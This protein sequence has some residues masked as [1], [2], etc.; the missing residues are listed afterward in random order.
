MLA[1]KNIYIC[2]FLNYFLGLYF[3][4]SLRT[5]LLFIVGEWEWWS[6]N[7]GVGV[8]EGL[9]LWLLTLVTGDRCCMTGNTLHVK[10]ETN[11]FG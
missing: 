4:G 3:L 10:D 2:I 1:N 6:G 8:G 11:L 9:W 7:G 5:S